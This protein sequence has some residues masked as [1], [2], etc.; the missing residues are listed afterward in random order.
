MVAIAE[1]PAITQQTSAPIEPLT[2]RVPYGETGLSVSRLCWGT[3]LMAHLRHNM[4]ESEAARIL[5]RGL[6]LGVNFWDTADGYKTHSHVG[7]ALRQVGRAN[8]ARVV[9]NSKSRAKTPEEAVADVD[10]FL[11][12]MDTEYIDTLMLHG[13][14]TVEELERRE[15][16][17][18]GLQRAKQAGKVR[19]AG[20]STHLGTGA[21][22]ERCAADP[23]IEVILTTVNID[24]QMLKG[25]MADHKPLVDRVYGA[26]KAICLMKTLAQGGLTTTPEQVRE[27][28]LHNLSLPYA[29]SVCVGVNSVAEVEFAVRVAAETEAGRS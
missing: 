19:A 12:E 3:G 6:E 5:M 11:K 8:R 24:G 14:E 21:I 4:S 16:A 9:V 27:A 2:Q 10:R 1:P 26:K 23:R 20:I 15:A 29:H 17:F 7:E 13:I 18:E 22:M 25:S 28:I